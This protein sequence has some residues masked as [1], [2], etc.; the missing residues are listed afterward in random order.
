MDKFS[1]YD[2][3]SYFLPGILCVFIC[4]QLTASGLEIFSP[5]NEILGGLILSIAAIVMGLVMHRITFFFISKL[6]WY[7]KLLQ[8]PIDK[9]IKQQEDDIKPVFEKLNA[10]YNTENLSAGKLFDEAYHYLEYN[11]KITAAKGFQSMYFFLRNLITLGII[12]IPV[13]VVSLLFLYNIELRMKILVLLIGSVAC[14]PVLL[15][16]AVFYRVKMVERVLYSYYIFKKEEGEKSGK[17]EKKMNR[18][19]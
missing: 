17:Q 13:S 10:S 12:W 15:W 16:A 5:V 2:F 6:P 8:K 7:K 14:L 9:I 3:M 1:L 18:F 19:F 4:L 11:D